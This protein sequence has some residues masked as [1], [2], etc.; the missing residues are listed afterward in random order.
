MM[1][2]GSGTFAASMFQPLRRGPHAE[3]LLPLSFLREQAAFMARAIYPRSSYGS[4]PGG[5]DELMFSILVEYVHDGD[6]S[7]DRGHRIIGAILG[8]TEELPS[9]LFEAATIGLNVSGR[10]AHRAGAARGLRTALDV[11]GVR[12][13]HEAPLWIER[14]KPPVPGAPGAGIPKEST[15]AAE[16]DEK[17]GKKKYGLQNLKQASK[18][19][20]LRVAVTQTVKTTKAAAVGILLRGVDEP[21]KRQWLADL[22]AS[23]MGDVIVSG[24]L[25]A[26]LIVIP[27][28]DES[29]KKELLQHELVVSTMA[30]GGNTVLNTYGDPLRELL[31]AALKGMP[32]LGEMAP[33]RLG[34]GNVVEV[35]G[36]RIREPEQVG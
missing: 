11:V 6:F 29:G 9:K 3:E 7:E 25:A 18:E 8:A 27:L 19:A 12:A 22:L 13:R 5:A 28:E 14:N 34:E 21:G 33:A 15:M 1:S 32:D 31:T 26:G 17:K 36:Q 4:T 20:A 16:T 2:Y 23:P 10:A 30:L 35:K 24:L